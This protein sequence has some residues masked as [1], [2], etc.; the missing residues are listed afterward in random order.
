MNKDNA[1]FLFVCMKERIITT[2]LH[3]TSKYLA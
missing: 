2:Y 3:A 1:V